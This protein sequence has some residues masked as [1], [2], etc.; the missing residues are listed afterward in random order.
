MSE[1]GDAVSGASAQSNPVISQLMLRKLIGWLGISLPFVLMIGNWISARA[2]PPGSISGY[3]YTDMRNF[4][5][6]GLSALGVFLLVYR[7]YEKLDGLITDVAGASVILVALCPTKPQVEK[8]HHL[9]MQQ[10][11]IGDLH[12][13]FAAITLIALGVMALRFARAQ[14]R[15]EVVIYRACAAMIF[16][17]VLLAA[18]SSLLLRSISVSSR[19]LFIFEVLAMLASGISWFVPGWAVVFPAQTY[20]MTPGPIQVAAPTD[21]GRPGTITNAP[22]R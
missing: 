2:S 18:A 10:N 11:V 14:R 8:R 20:A 1:W 16:S 6:G 19:P 17:C 21:A 22:M 13:L 3:Y 12:V 7:G 9:T 15:P 4:F 5:V